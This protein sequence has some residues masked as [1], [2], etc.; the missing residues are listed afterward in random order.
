MFSV[1]NQMFGARTK[2]V[3]LVNIHVGSSKD[4]DRYKK[5]RQTKKETMQDKVQENLKG[6]GVKE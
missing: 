3:W 2:N 5:K 6:M 1:K 4:A